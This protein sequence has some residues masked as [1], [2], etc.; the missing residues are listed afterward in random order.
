LD[1]KLKLTPKPIT[2]NEI[3]RQ[4]KNWL[5]LK[6]Y[7][8]FHLLAGMGAF[9]GAPDRIAVKDGQVYFIEVKKPKGGIQSDNQIEFQRRIEEKGG[10]YLLVRSL[11]ELIKELGGR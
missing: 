2:E 6:G 11:E 1:K 5:T 4:V 9:K 8:S 3:K 7:F 10:K